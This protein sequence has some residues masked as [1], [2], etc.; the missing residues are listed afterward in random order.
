MMHLTLISCIVS[1]KGRCVCVRVCVCVLFC[2]STLVMFLV[3][4]KGEPIR[5]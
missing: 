4:V 3:L 1:R 2:A 5:M